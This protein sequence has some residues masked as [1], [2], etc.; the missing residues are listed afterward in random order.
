VN[1][2][3]VSKNIFR[4]KALTPQYPKSE[5]P[6]ILFLFSDTGGGHRS[7]AEAIIEAINLEFP[8]QY[9]CDM[10][11]ILANYA[12]APINR[13]PQIYPPLSRLPTLWGLG[14][15]ISD[16]RRRTRAFY[17]AIW[18]YIRRKLELLFEERPSDLLVSVHQLVNVP[19]ARLAEE[20]HLP[21]VTVVTD[22]VTTHSAWYAPRARHVVVPTDEAFRRGL[23]NGMRPEQMSVVGMPVADR[24]TR[25]PGERTQ[26]R[27][28][29]G[30]EVGKPLVLMVGGGEGM[31]PLEAMAV[32]LD[33]SGLEV[34]LAVICGRNQK[35]KDRLEARAWH[36]PVHVYGFVREMPQFMHAADILVTKAGPGTISEAFIA[37]LP[38]VLYSKMPGQEDGNVTYVRDTG[39]GVWAP[40]PA[41]MIAAV[42]RWLQYPQE[43]EDAA[44]KCRE[45]ARPRAARE[46]A[47]ILARYIEGN[48]PCK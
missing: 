12:P 15:R 42:R 32:A 13:A 27:A 11:D 9:D 8:G 26:I 3:A 48:G 23:N 33:T 40:E 36:I 22:M 6:R 31:G 46:I 21:F 38:I 5:R 34:G 16:G 30:W 19:V 45:L 7:A 35:L 44:Q 37:G 41:D 43:W 10:V 14:Y 28:T 25:T 4:E 17:T 39:S 20:H 2:P 24:F 47:Q 29:L 1:W 18:P